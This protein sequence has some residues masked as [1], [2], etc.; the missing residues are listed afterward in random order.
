M[1]EAKSLIHTLRARAAQLT[2]AADTLAAIDSIYG[3]GPTHSNGKRPRSGKRHLSAA[4]RMA[5]VRA[6]RARWAKIRAAKKGGR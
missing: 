3:I 2:N 1:N 4:G 6:Q 5:I